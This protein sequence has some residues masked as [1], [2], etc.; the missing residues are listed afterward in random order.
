MNDLSNFCCFVLCSCFRRIWSSP[1]KAYLLVYQAVWLVDFSCATV[2]KSMRRLHQ[3][4]LL[5]P[6]PLTDRINRIL[7][8]TCYWRSSL[9]W[10]HKASYYG[11]LTLLL[12]SR[13]H[14]SRPENYIKNSLTQNSLSRPTKMC[15]FWYK[16]GCMGWYWYI[17]TINLVTLDYA[18]WWTK[19][20][21]VTW[22]GY[23]KQTM[24]NG[25]RKM[26]IASCTFLPPPPP[27]P[28]T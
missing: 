27:P 5:I 3:Y 23:M 14:F 8:I 1:K 19:Y 12:D 25:S 22:P 13:D 28:P 15:S 20:R 4:W 21:Q 7:R 11:V 24:R 10:W 6:S 2:T 9:N 16:L 18:R 26:G 17:Y